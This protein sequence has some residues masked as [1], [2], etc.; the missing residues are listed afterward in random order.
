MAAHLS[1]LVVEDSEPDVILLREALGRSGRR[2]QIAVARD[3]VEALAHLAASALSS[4]HPDLILLDLN[5]PRM[6]GREFLSRV[7]SDPLLAI[8]PI[9]VLSTSSSPDDIRG[10]YERSCNAYVVKPHGLEDFERV[11]GQLET[12]WGDCVSQA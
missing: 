9:V 8:I 6:D 12:F 4:P 10:S 11:I 2:H 7:K 1:I 3:G 5:M